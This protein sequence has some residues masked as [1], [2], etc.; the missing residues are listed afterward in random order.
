MAAAKRR[1][2]GLT[3]VAV[4]EVGSAQQLPYPTATFDGVV[5][6]LAL[7]FVPDAQAALAKMTRVARP[8]GTVSLY[9]WDYNYPVFF[10]TRY[11]AAVEQVI[12]GRAAGDERN[13]WPVC[14][15]NGLTRLTSSQA[16]LTNAAVLPLTTP[17]VFANADDLWNSFSLGVGPAGTVM[18]ALDVG[19]RQAVRAALEERLPV[20][21]DGS[22]HL[23]ARAWA[24]AATAL[25]RGGARNRADDRAAKD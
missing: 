15:R 12:G 9:V 21:P 14:S 4:F 6:G 13:R 7:T 2:R 11:W 22:V 1:W 8:G 5:S 18:G 17:T 3:D 10:L 20:A 19:Q 24:F 23:S 25:E 16:R